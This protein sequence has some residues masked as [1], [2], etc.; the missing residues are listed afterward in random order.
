MAPTS[1]GVTAS[2]PFFRRHI[3]CLSESMETLPTS[4]V[5]PRRSRHPSAGR[6][7]LRAAA[8][9]AGA[10]CLGGV[11]PVFAASPPEPA[12]AAPSPAEPS[13]PSGFVPFD[14]STQPQA[15][16]TRVQ[17]PDPA[18]DRE[19]QGQYGLGVFLLVLGGLVSVAFMVALFRIVMRR[20]WDSN[21]APA[22]HGRH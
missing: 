1:S 22:S 8:V 5:Q 16:E 14:R 17:V 21:H 11:S 19:V 2:R 10:V 15:G 20:T 9:L 13:Q 4:P 18:S 7:S 12:V 3:T 6:A